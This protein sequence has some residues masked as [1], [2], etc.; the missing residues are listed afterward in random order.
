MDRLTSLAAFARVVETGGFSA[1]ARRLGMSTTMVS[2]HVQA[3]EDRLDARLLQRTTR[4][5]SLTEIGRAYYERAVQIL[6][7]IE[8]A[9]RIASAEQATPRGT[10]RVHTSTHI[11]R[12]I[13]PVVREY[14]A[15]HPAV[16][17]DLTIAERMVDLIEE[18]F[19]LAI[20]TLP[21]PDSSLIVR[22]LTPWRHIL[23]CAPDYLKS[24]PAVRTPAD[25]AEHNC[26]RYALY[27]YGDEWRF[28]GPDGR[29]AAVRIS[30]NTLT[31]SAD[32]LR[33]LALAGAGVM[34][35]PSFVAAEDLAAG[36]LVRMMPAFRPVEFAI[37]AVYPHRH[38]VSSKVRRFIDLLAERFAEHRRWMN[39]PAELPEG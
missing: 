28:D 34:L 18:G 11:I 10:L 24:Q 16:T 17:V 15:L 25:L 27:P 12:F 1:A 36:R 2:N 37:S 3:L 8:E 6:G 19:D 33:N 5:V 31:N 20:R 30:G 35:A 7:D 14:L 9:D 21:P 4:K 32:L 39:P 38:H 22:R 29:M 23:C 13:S 26:L